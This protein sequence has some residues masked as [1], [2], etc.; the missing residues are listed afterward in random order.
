[1]HVMLHF[2]MLP[3]TSK[4]KEKV[5][6]IIK[7]ADLNGDGKFTFNEF[8]VLAD[9]VR[10]F[11]ML[12]RADVQGKLFNKYDRDGSNALS[13]AELAQLLNEIGLVPASRAEQKEFAQ[14]LRDVDEDGGGSLDFGEFQVLCQRIVEKLGALH[15]DQEMEIATRLGF[16][17]SETRQF[18]WIFGQLDDDGS[19]S[20]D[21]D[22][23]RKCLANMGRLV[24]AERF[25][26]AFV[27]IDEDCSGQLDFKE[28][29]L[30]MKT[31]Q[32]GEGIFS[33]DT[34]G[35]PHQPRMLDDKTLQKSLSFMPLSTDYIKSLRHDALV[36]LFCNYFDVKPDTNIHEALNMRTVRALNEK[37]RK[38]GIRCR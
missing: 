2:G 4:E 26:E 14:L 23:V 29:L 5:A 30:L 18:R 9:K 20:L 15:Y 24:P 32:E 36:E 13:T 19:G 37:A 22:E 21:Q 31:L 8:L 7:S 16:Q 12:Q 34:L 25:R 3:Q 35:I 28:F 33:D 1:M 17:D 38:I 6:E 11:L 10:R 27:S